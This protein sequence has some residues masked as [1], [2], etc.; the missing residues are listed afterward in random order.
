MRDNPRWVRIVDCFNG[1]AVDVFKIAQG[2]AVDISD[3]EDT[4]ELAR[5]YNDNLNKLRDLRTADL[6]EQAS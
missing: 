3:G 5:I 2:I 4:F 1:S 6:P